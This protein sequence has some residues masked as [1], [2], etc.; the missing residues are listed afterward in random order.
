M[1]VGISHWR[2]ARQGHDH[3]VG[4]NYLEKIQIP[5]LPSLYGSMLAG[6]GYVVMGAGVPMKIPGVLDL[7]VNHEAATYPLHVTG[8]EAGD[9]TT[10]RFDPRD[11]KEGA[12]APL[13]RPRFLAIVADGY[14]FRRQ[15]NPSM[16]SAT[17]STWARCGGWVGPSGWP[18]ATAP[19]GTCKGPG[20]RAPPACR[21][22][23]RAPRSGLISRA[24]RSPRTVGCGWCARWMSGSASASLLPSA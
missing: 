9:D 3:P 2:L 22:A 19:G 1:G 10:L 20:R 18:V 11:Y 23:P 21:W 7:F 5:H 16:A 24:R 15:A 8:A 6:A 12:L 14:N 17:G 13:V 4:I